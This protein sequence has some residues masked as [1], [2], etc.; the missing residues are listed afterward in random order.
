MKIAQPGEKPVLLS[1][2][3]AG[4]I[5]VFFLALLSIG[6]AANRATALAGVLA[7]LALV[8]SGLLLY[9]YRDPDR[10]SPDDPSKIYAPGDGRVL[11]VEQE[12][13]GGGKT[14]RIFLSVFDVH[15]QRL[16]CS[17]RVQ[18]IEYHK[19]AFQAAMAAAAR[20]NERLALTLVPDGRPEPV[21]VEQIAGLLARRI[22]CWMR[23][24]ASGQ[25]GDRY[26]IIHFGSQVAVHLPPSAAPIVIPGVRVAA[27]VTPIAQWR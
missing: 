8:A 6:G 13:D 16:P 12:R 9:F 26:G 3:A 11:S 24:G 7:L 5:V 23:E 20:Q 22:E 18:A 10:P 19:G 21:V 25:A 4:T 17:G 15:V 27:G 14:V 2:I 1:F